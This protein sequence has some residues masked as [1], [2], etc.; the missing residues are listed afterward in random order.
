MKRLS[1]LLPLLFCASAAF[2]Q[3]PDVSVKGDIFL[4]YRTTENGPN[5]VRWYDSMGHH[6]IAAL[7]FHL[8]PG[9]RVYVAERFE[10][11]PHDG[12]NE[13]LDEY[14]VED[15]GIWRLGK[16]YLPFGRQGILRESAR[17]ARGDT[18]LLFERFPV[19][20]AICDNGQNRT[21][22]VV[23]RFGSVIGVSFAFG[24]NFG[25]QS[26]SLDVVRRPEDAPGIGRGYRTAFGVDFARHYK[27]YTLQAEAVALRR[28]QTVDDPNTEICDLAL[29]LQP[30]KYAALTAAW[31]RDW[32]RSVNF[33]RLQGKF[34]VTRSVWVEPIV[35][36]RD[37]DFFEL[38]ASLRV[39]F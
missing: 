10:R 38:G 8:E 20:L 4:H 21:R 3:T 6:S 37:G 2:A 34:L 22:G 18:N 33:L 23:G 16:Q 11:I 5:T 32:G 12:D 26:T 28:G 14:Y 9:F 29:T 24:N 36:F 13:Q 27:I 30:S 31:S 1:A 39:K 19:S 17:A 15:P 7:E 35:R 25:I